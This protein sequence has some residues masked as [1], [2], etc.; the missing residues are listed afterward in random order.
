MAKVV[1]FFGRNEAGGNAEAM[2]DTVMDHNGDR[3]TL[4]EEK[5]DSAS[6]LQLRT[7]AQFDEAEG[8]NNRAFE[9]VAARSPLSDAATLFRTPFTAPSS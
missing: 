4:G 9:M 8:S 6:K 1:F 5:I 2:A 7:L 3:V